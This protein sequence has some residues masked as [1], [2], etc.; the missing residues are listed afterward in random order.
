MSR[1]SDHAGSWSPEPARTIGTRAALLSGQVARTRARPHHHLTHHHDPGLD[2]G[3]RGGEEGGPGHGCQPPGGGRVVTVL[4]RDAA[5]NLAVPQS[6]SHCVQPRQ[7]TGPPCRAAPRRSARPDTEKTKWKTG[8]GWCGRWRGP[9]E[10]GMLC[11]RPALCPASVK[12]DHW[13]RLRDLC[14]IFTVSLSN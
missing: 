10:R 8:G 6:G 7:E 13:E 14:E 1:L 12:R 9:L 4:S 5:A 3:G 11:P 2:H